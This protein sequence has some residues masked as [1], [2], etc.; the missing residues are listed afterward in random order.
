MPK[1]RHGRRTKIVATL[2]P[3]SSDRAVI[4]SLFEAGVDVFRLN[5]SHG[6][7]ADHAARYETLRMLERE[8]SHPIA[9]LMDLQGPKLRVGA[10]ESGSVAL[11][12]GVPFRLDLDA[13]PGDARRVA[14]P[15]P[16]LFAVL[17]SG[18]EIL[19]DDGRVRLQVTRGGADFADTI[20]TVGGVLSNRKGVNLPG[21]NVPLSALSLKDRQDLAFALD[22]GVDWIGAVVRATSRRRDGGAR[23]DR[24]ARRHRLQD[25]EA[26]R[27]PVPTRDRC[28]V[29]CHHGRTGRLGRGAAA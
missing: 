14:L 16:E 6:T 29:G 26:G 21:V 20:V 11:Q 15:H 7:H 12:N 19:L 3:A 17:R 25:R 5:A 22:L 24:H 8:A 18:A 2:G 23:P 9:V 10:F 13:T 1:T 27:D 4:R 28:G